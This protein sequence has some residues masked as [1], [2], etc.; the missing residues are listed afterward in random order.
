MKIGYKLFAEAFSPAEL[1]RQ[2]VR[3]EEVGFDFVEISDHFHP[4]LPE[5]GHAPA[6]WSVLPA[7]A[8]RTERIGLGTGVTCPF[9]RY[10]PAIVAQAAATTACLAPGR[11]FLGL[12]TGERLNEHIVGQGWPALPVRRE[13]LAESIAIIRLLWSGGYRSY[14]GQHLN[15]ETARV[16][17]LPEELPGII[18]AAGGPR[19][20]RLAAE[21]GDGLFSVE[22]T[23]AVME[24]YRAAGGDGPRYVE[25]P[26]A[27]APDADA[28]AQSAHRL[29]RFG[30]GGWKVTVEL[31]NPANFAAATKS[32]PVDA[33][34][35]AFACGPDVET[36]LAMIRRF[37]EAGYDHLAL[38]NAGPDP[39]GFL[40]FFAREL[41]AP[42]RAMASGA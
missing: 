28:A 33:M 23:P 14:R 2:A 20:A 35:E 24:A 26:L 16:F 41:S 5:H 4:W 25:V 42:L 31:P 21:H 39:D 11:V 1:V 40:D 38:I 6:A 8:M 27:W 10:H 12:G 36:H 29:F 30:D 7:I 15:L 22:S 18:V 3:A 13:M 32:V 34:R 37:A 17:D 19:A 9:I